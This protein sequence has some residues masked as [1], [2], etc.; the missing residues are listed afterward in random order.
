MPLLIVKNYSYGKQISKIRE[1]YFEFM[2]VRP[3]IAEDLGEALDLVTATLTY[4]THEYTQ[5]EIEKALTKHKA[6]LDSRDWEYK[7]Y[8]NI[9]LEG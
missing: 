6:K 5:E 2:E 9:E 8:V 4:I 3:K 1:E 7:G